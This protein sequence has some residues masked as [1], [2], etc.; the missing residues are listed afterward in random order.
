MSCGDIKKLILSNENQPFSLWIIKCLS[1]IHSVY[2][3]FV[4]GVP[5]VAQQEDLI[6]EWNYYYLLLLF[7]TPRDRK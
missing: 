4:V 2:L 6:R 7:L 5:S 3:N 1:D